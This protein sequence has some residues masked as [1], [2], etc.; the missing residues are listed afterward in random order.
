L[1]SKN[2]SIRKKPH[3]VSTQQR[4]VETFPAFFVIEGGWFALE[5]PEVMLL[6]FSF[7][8]KKQY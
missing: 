2:Q 1:K 5:N 8:K 3:L 4:P 6:F 7:S